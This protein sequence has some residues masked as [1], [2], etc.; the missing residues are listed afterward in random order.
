MKP[1]NA[2]G[3]PS[4]LD[5]NQP[6]CQLYEDVDYT[7]FWS[8]EQQRKLDQAEHAVVRELLPASG[9]R[10][11]D[12]GCGYGRLSDCY[13]GRFKEAV[14]LDGSLSLLRQAQER[15]G[16]R[17]IYIAGDLHHLP[18]QAAAFDNILMV[19]VF[20]HVQNDRACL[21]EFGR[22]LSGGGRLIFTYKNKLYPIGVVKWLAHP[23][24]ESPFSLEPSGVGTTLISHHPAY[25]R[26]VLS[27][28]GFARLSYRGVGVLDRLANKLGRLGKYAPTGEHFARFFGATRL[29]PWIFCRAVQGGGAAPIESN[30]LEDLLLCP[31]CGG[32]LATES[33]GHE[34]AACGRL[35]PTIDGILDFRIDNAN[36]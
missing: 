19:R 32:A 29:A 20:H 26:K 24:L 3:L 34:C 13:L 4:D 2:A 16:G 30:R 12:I 21:S 14:L 11:I 7:R 23:T 36:H 31:L 33:Q 6:A 22:V 8:G 28:A 10:L 35:Y 1:W 15:N 18:F 9:R 17:G 5:P 27:Q 25:I